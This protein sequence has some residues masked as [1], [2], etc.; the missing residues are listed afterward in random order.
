MFLTIVLEF[1][2][3]EGEVRNAEERE[4]LV[5]QLLTMKQKQAFLRLKQKNDLVTGVSYLSIF[6]FLIFFSYSYMFLS[7]GIFF[8]KIDSVDYLLSK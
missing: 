7:I 2:S 3:L 8:L 6:S 5:K 1:F 4:K